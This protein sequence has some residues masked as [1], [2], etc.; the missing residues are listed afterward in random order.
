VPHIRLR[1]MER[2]H[3]A[4]TGN[5][6]SGTIAEVERVGWLIG[7]FSHAERIPVG[8]SNGLHLLD[9]RT[10]E[11]CPLREL[12]CLWGIKDADGRFVKS[13][14]LHPN[15]NWS[16]D[17]RYVIVRSDFG[18]G[19]DGVQIYLVDVSTWEA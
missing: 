9:Q 19:V 16:P 15:P 11:L 6:A 5:R 18:Q 4:R 13:E 12:S 8:S 7:G 3:V 2:G 17:G 14:F 10:R 1:L